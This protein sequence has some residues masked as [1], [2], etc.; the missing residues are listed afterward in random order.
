MFTGGKI[1]K[2]NIYHSDG[3]YI[4][5]TYDGALKEFIKK[6]D[7]GKNIKLMSDGKE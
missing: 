4:G 1:I 7:K 6:A 3:N 5:V 2:L